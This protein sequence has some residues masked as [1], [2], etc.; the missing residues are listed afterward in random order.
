MSDS[1]KQIVNRYYDAW[2]KGGDFSNVPLANDF[3]FVGP[4]DQF[5][6]AEAFLAMSKQFGPMVDKLEVHEQLTGGDTVISWFTFGVKQL[7]VEPFPCAERIR[8]V[9]G[10]IRSSE[11]LYDA[12]EIAKAMGR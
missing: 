6:S 4:I 9:D 3:K 11:L 8:V 2:R 1:N 10:K 7:P 12:R 5:D